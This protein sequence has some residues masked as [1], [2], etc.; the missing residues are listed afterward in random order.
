MNKKDK[1]SASLTSDNLLISQID[2]NLPRQGWRFD[3]YKQKLG[4]F[5]SHHGKYDQNWTFMKAPG[6]LMSCVHP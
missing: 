6:L 3:C 2:F 4:H 5:M 1:Q